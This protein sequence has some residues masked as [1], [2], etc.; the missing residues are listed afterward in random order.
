MELVAA[1]RPFIA[2]PLESHFE[3]RFHVRHRLDRY[4]ARDWID[5]HDASPEALA[6]SIV[7]LIGTK[8]SYLPVDG[9]G[10]GRAAALIAELL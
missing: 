8:P 4:G 5:F 2:L 1:G 3:Q 10:A 7:G 6:D 9:G